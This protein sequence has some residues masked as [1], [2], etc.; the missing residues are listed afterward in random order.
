MLSK[1][2]G[3]QTDNHLSWKNHIDQSVH[4]LSEACYVVT[5]TLHVSNTDTLK[6]ISLACFHFVMMYGI[7][8]WWNSPNSKQVFTLQKNFFKIMAS[9]KAR[10]L[11]SGMFKRP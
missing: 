5:S 11:C 10:N 7:I 6:S 3:L 8:F 1:C 9:V 2:L 4:Q